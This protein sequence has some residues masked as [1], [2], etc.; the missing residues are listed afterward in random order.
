[1]KDL[2]ALAQKI[3]IVPGSVEEALRGGGDSV[4]ENALV[5]NMVCAEEIPCQKQNTVCVTY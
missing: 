5:G 1:M 2:R 4:R 3:T